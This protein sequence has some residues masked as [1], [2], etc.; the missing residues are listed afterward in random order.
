MGSFRR[1][2]GV[3]AFACGCGVAAKPLPRSG[4]Q[5][6]PGATDAMTE[7]ATAWLTCFGGRYRSVPPG[8]VVV[9]A[10]RNCQIV[11]TDG[12][13]AFDAGIVPDLRLGPANHLRKV[14]PGALVKA[15]VRFDRLHLVV[16][17]VDEGE[18]STLGSSDVHE[19][20]ACRERGLRLDLDCPRES[21]MLLLA[22]DQVAKVEVW[23]RF[24]VRWK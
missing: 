2:F 23:N 18:W 5:V 10:Y 16:R 13:S 17:Y 6:M 21:V 24:A 20:V 3:L 15:L 19:Q 1:L 14:D 12:S 4:A 9:S 7:S 8:V 11:V 22:H